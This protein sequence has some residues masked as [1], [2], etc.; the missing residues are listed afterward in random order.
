VASLVLMVVLVWLKDSL[1]DL[2][3]AFIGQYSEHVVLKL[4][5]DE[6]RL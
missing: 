2:Q 5:E 3:I 4:W 1:E 6:V